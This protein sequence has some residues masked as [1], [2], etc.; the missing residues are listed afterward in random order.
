MINMKRRVGGGKDG[1]KRPRVK[2]SQ[3]TRPVVASAL[4][5]DT[6]T[7]DHHRPLTLSVIQQMLNEFETFWYNREEIE[8]EKS[9]EKWFVGK[10]YNKE[11]TVIQKI[12][13]HQMK[14]EVSG[15]QVFCRLQTARG[16]E[17]TKVIAKGSYGTVCTLGP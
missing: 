10:P 3:S 7:T 9:V 8:W 14:M 12:T 16:I 6:E 1:I 11:G 13:V 4:N 2:M 17:Q 5:I 15:D